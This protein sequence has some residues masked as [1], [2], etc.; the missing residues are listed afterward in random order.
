[1]TGG[2]GDD[3]LEG[4]DGADTFVITAELLPIFAF[5]EG[6]EMDEFVFEPI[7]ENSGNDTITDYDASE[8]TLFFEGT[9][10][11][12]ITSDGTD[13]TVTHTG[14]TVTLL[15]VGITSEEDEQALVDSFLFLLA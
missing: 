3:E 9:G 14:G 10:L 8:D 15:G 13:T 7:G 1:L 12:D 5:G 11:V 2:T 4:G 6:V